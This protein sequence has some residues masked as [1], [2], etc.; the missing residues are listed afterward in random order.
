MRYIWWIQT[1]GKGIKT[2]VDMVWKLTMYNQE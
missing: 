2:E 1:Y